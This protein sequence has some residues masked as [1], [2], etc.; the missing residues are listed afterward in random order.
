MPK[1]WPRAGKSPRFFLGG[2]TPTTLPAPL[3][4]D[5]LKACRTRFKLA[6]DCEI[7]LEA[8]P[9]TVS[10]DLLQ[11][12]KN[13]GYNRISI[14]VQ[15][16]HEDQLKLLERV[17][18][19]EEI[20]LTVATA[21]EAGFDNLSLDLMFALPGQ[22]MQQWKSNLVSGVGQKPGASFHL[23]S[24][25]LNRERCFTSCMLRANSQCRRKI[26]NWNS[27]SERSRH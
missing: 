14:G 7:T 22:T 13:S 27:T 8:N 21:R 20:H 9:A 26:S 17:H 1:T 19:V 2:G 24:D 4:D 6:P 18:S 16:F 25:H 12:I 11:A 3:L 5:I 23:Q 15:S 10:L